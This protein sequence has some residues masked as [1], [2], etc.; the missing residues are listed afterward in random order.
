MLNIYQTLC[1]YRL[2]NEFCL[3]NM[4]CAIHTHTR[5][6][7]L[8][9]MC[10]NMLPAGSSQSYVDFSLVHRLKKYACAEKQPN[11]RVSSS[12]GLDARP[13]RVRRPAQRRRSVWLLGRVPSGSVWTTALPLQRQRVGGR[14][15]WPGPLVPQTHTLTH[16]C[17]HIHMHAHTHA[18]T[19][20][21]FFPTASARTN[22]L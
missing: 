8:L 4:I 17:T 7:L 15:H 5:I 21:F 2:C 18:H 13:L 6:H 10:S 19:P 20:S 9:H 1:M 14:T 16:I 12:R 3:L 22:T 11:K